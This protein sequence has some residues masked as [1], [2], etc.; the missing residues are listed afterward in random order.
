MDVNQTL[1]QRLRALRDAHAYSLDTLAERSKVSRSTIS[2]IERGQSSPTATVLD[3]LATALGVPLASLFAAEGATAEA[4]S[5]VARQ[6]EQLEWTDP[7][8]GYRRRHLSAAAASPIQLVEVHFPPGQKVAYETGARDADIHQQVWLLEGVMRITVADQSWQ[9][10]AGDCLTMRL[11]APIVFD[12]PG[13]TLARY[14][15]ALVT[16]PYPSHRRMP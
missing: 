7:A 12:N 13:T 5:A 14:L 15:V 16:L 1:A 6:A 8:S 11:D 10:G 2:L 4:P 3:K 9:L